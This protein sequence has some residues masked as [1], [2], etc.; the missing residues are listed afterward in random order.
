MLLSIQLLR[1]AIRSTGATFFSNHHIKCIEQLFLVSL[2]SSLSS[3]SWLDDPFSKPVLPVQCLQTFLLSAF[4]FSRCLWKAPC[5]LWITHAM[6]ML[7]HETQLM[8]WM[9]FECFCTFSSHY[10]QVSHKTE[11]QYVDLNFFLRQ[12]FHASS[13]CPYAKSGCTKMSELVVL[14][15]GI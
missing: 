14:K 1:H 4:L 5:C 3:Y 15:L 10:N 11:S 6:K 13:S 7:L 2:Y 8:R 12:L 9:L